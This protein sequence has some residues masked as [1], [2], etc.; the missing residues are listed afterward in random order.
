MKSCPA[1]SAGWA[2]PAKTS[3]TGRSGSLRIARTR[4]RSRHHQ[5]GALVGGEAAGEADGQGLDVEQALDRAQLVGGPAVPRALQADPLAHE[6]D[7]PLLLRAVRGPQ[8]LVGDLVHAVPVLGL[9]EVVLPVR[10]QA[11]GEEGP[12]LRP[13]PALGVHAVGHVGDPAVG[14]V[15]PQAAPHRRGHLAVQACSRRS[16]WTRGGWPSR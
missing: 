1:R 13:D 8:L 15:R 16:R 7:E 4:S 6:P 10:A 11:P 14:L 3:W 9:E 2:L 5:H 12:H